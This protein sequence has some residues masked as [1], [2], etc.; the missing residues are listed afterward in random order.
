MN[1]MPESLS[2]RAPLDHSFCGG[3]TARCRPSITKS[4]GLDQDHSRPPLQPFDGSNFRGGYS[5]QD[6]FCH[7]QLKMKRRTVAS[8]ARDAADW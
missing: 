4:R 6:W 8:I 5:L 3:P 7:A 2:L 1:F